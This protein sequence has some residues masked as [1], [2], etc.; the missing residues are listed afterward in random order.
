MVLF[1]F[2]KKRENFNYLETW[3]NN[4]SIILYYIR[5]FLNL[6][7]FPYHHYNFYKY[8]N[9]NIYIWK[10]CRLK[11]KMEE[12]LGTS[13]SDSSLQI[14]KNTKGEPVSNNNLQRTKKCMRLNFSGDSESTLTEE[15]S[16][17]QC[18]KLFENAQSSSEVQN[19]ISDS[20]LNQDHMD[21][22]V[23]LQ[24]TSGTNLTKTFLNLNSASLKE[25][26]VN[27]V[28]P[29]QSELFEVL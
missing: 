29:Y 1:L 28:E 21:K 14:I 19:I 13:Q 4:K 26:F 8:L 10:C 12:K 3:E 22:V 25:L 20:Y 16:K 6:I 7:V 11:K 9:T 5:H 17:L 23:L 15:E 27:P 18:L 2:Q 24:T